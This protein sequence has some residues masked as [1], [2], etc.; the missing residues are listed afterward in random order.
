MAL[1]E[2]HYYFINE[3]AERWQM[4]LNDLAY[5]VG[6]GYLRASV[7]LPECRVEIGQ[8]D[9]DDQWRRAASQSH[10]GYV[11]L[12][13]LSC[14]RIFSGSEFY[15]DKFHG[16]S[17]DT[18]IRVITPSQGIMILPGDVMI[19]KAECKRFALAHGL[20]TAEAD[21]KSGRPS[22]MPL[23]LQ[24]YERRYRSGT[25]KKSDAT[26]AQYLHHWAA[27]HMPGDA[28]PSSKTIQNNISQH[29]KTLSAKAPA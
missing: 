22:V 9:K 5:Y 4:S 23:I 19:S 29:R 16:G 7:S 18:I 24:E 15:F 6:H 26:E 10:T 11:H 14:R 27:Q 3:V 17:D 8:L 21:R 1:P 25:L 2:R 28:I 12:Y 13:P 20:V